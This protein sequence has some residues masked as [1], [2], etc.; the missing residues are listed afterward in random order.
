MKKFILI[1]VVLFAILTS[2]SYYAYYQTSGDK[3]TETNPEIIKIYSGDIEQD[4]VIIGSVTAD[5]LG[6]AD[7]AVKHL[8][9]KAS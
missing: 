9:K 1:F 8:K 4:Y 3:L 2:C 6:D 5:V 7:A